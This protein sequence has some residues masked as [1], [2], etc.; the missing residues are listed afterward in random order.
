[1]NKSINKMGISFFIVFFFINLLMI[2]FGCSKSEEQ[3]VDDAT[4][5][6]ANLVYY[7]MPGWPFCAKIQT[8]V[9]G[10]E[11][12]NKGVLACEI[13]NA[14]DEKGK[15][16]I[17]ELGFKTHG[18]VFYDPDGNI[19]KKIDGHKMTEEEIDSAV[20]EILGI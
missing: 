13:R 8:I 6:K 16:E 1:M 19:L 15:V 2:N 3:S 11:E 7:S 4:Q 9:N 12:T 5:L 17:A 20:N 14:M 10:L 18:M